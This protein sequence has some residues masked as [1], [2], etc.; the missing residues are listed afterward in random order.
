MTNTWSL[1]TLDAIYSKSKNEFYTPATLQLAIRCEILLPN[2]SVMVLHN[3]NHIL[4]EEFHIQH[5]HFRH[6]VDGKLNS[7]LLLS[8]NSFH[9]QCMHAF[10]LLSCRVRNALNHIFGTILIGLTGKEK[11]LWFFKEQLN[12]KYATFVR[13]ACQ[14][15]G[16]TSN[17]KYATFVK[18][19]EWRL[20]GVTS[21]WQIDKLT[22]RLI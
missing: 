2:N 8:G 7:Y 14:S 9:K 13:L 1:I 22:I 19:L 11:L 18:E 3:I 5:K 12:T 10:H 17:W 6:S 21:N 15:L 4:F 20:K 16:K